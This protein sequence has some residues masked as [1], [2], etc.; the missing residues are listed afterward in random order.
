MKTFI[1]WQGNK[2]KHLQH[3]LPYV[4]QE[5][6]NGTFDGTYIEPFI[7]SGALFLKL[8]PEKWIINDLNK[9]IINIWKNVK[10]DPEKFIEKF[11]KF[12]E[13]FIPMTRS[14]KIMY[15]KKKVKEIEYMKYD[16]KRAILFMLMKFCSYMGHIFIKNKF[17]FAGLDLPISI[18]NDYTFLKDRYYNLLYNVSTFLNTRN[19][20]IYNKDYIE[21]LHKAKKGDFIFLDPPYIEEQEYQFNY[22]KD[23]DINENFLLILKEELIKLDKKGVKWM[24]T[25]ADTLQVK[26]VFKHFT[27]KE[28]PVYRRSSNIYKKELLILSKNISINNISNN[29]RRKTKKRHS[30]HRSTKKHCLT[31]SK[32]RK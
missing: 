14:E 10:R 20:K 27:I 24:M 22:N 28:F 3:I 13:K 7:G 16:I 19:G 9:D 31:R 26:D 15:C 1:K 8:E 23:E 17:M 18:N 6:I 25:N 29:S 2:S 21:I 4:P 30:K 5:I 11:K 12:G 32:L